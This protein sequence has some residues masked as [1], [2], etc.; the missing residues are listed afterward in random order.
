MALFRILMPV[1]AVLHV[2]FVALTA[3]VGAFADGGSIAERLLLVLVH[4]LSAVGLL[5][6][7]FVGSLPVT[8]LRVIVALLIVNVAADLILALLIAV[9]SV[10]GDWELALVFAVVPAIGIVYAL[11]R[12]RS[13]PA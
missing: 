1:L 11:T 6:M 4:P 5:V 13:Q 12:P 7:V 9:G 8:V 3:T 2:L 10:K